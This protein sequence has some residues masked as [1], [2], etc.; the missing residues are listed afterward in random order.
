MNVDKGY[1]DVPVD[2]SIDLKSEITK[3]K[4]E[5]NAVILA[6]YYQKGERKISCSWQ[7]YRNRSRCY[8]LY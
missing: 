2:K 6:H 7:L 5:K 8:P 3:L 4:K 1:V